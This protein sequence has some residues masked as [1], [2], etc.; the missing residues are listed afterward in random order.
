MAL[1]DAGLAPHQF[2]VDG[3][4]VSPASIERGKRAIYGKNSFRGED[5]AFR[6]RHFTAVA[7]GY[8]VS[9]RVREQVRLSA[10]NLLEPGLLAGEVYDFVFCRNLLIY[11]D[12]ATQQQ[13]FEI[14]K[15]LTHVDG[16]LFIGPAEGNLLGRMGMRSIGV[17][18]SFAFRRHS[19]VEPEPVPCVRRQ[20]GWPQPRQ[21]PVRGRLQHRRRCSGLPGRRRRTMPRACWRGLPSWP[22][23][24]AA[25]KPGRPA[26]AICNAQQ[27]QGFY[28]KALYLE[29]QHPEAL[30]QLAAL[31]ASQGDAAGARRL[32]DR[33]ARSGRAADHEDAEAIDDCWNRIG[34][35]GDKSCPL[36]VDHIHCRNCAVYSAAATRLLDRYALLQESH[37]QVAVVAGE[38]IVTRSLL[39]FRLGEEWLGLATRCLVE[40][41]PSGDSF[42]AAP[43]LASAAGRRQCARSARGL[44]VAGG[45]AGFGR[46]CHGHA[47]RPGHAAHADHCGPWRSGGGAGG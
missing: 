26:T 2:K 43:A 34:I 9:E 46:Q 30:A 11:F 17:P 1:L 4:D 8:Q 12:L 21:R 10:G 31:L 35:Y 37:E 29:P 45:T 47:G 16:V 19:P 18:Q 42:A 39:M 24:A 40:I 15:R 27:A 32:H 6:E 28:R 23:K 3:L 25:M 5:I 38:E 22:M 20:A 13:V 33:A 14:L 36:L 44:P 41:A 7:E